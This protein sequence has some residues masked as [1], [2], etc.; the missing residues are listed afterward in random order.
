M[1]IE[2]GNRIVKADEIVSISHEFKRPDKIPT[3][4][5]GEIDYKK[6]S[7]SGYIICKLRDGSEIKETFTIQSKFDSCLK[8]IKSNLLPGDA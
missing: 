6:L 5:R 1:F 8:S 2:I 4:I 3:N 7:G